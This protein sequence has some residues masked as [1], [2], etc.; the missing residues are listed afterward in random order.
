MKTALHA[1]HVALEAKMADVAGWEMPL[2]YRSVLDEYG[3]ARARAS[4]FDISHIGRLRIRGDGAL[5]LLE[6]LCTADVAHQED[7]TA[8]YTLLCNERGGI[9]DDCLLLR[10]EGCWLLTTNAINRRKVLEH[11]QANAGDDVKVDDQTEKTSQLAVIGPAAAEILDAV[12]PMKVSSMPAGAVKTGSLLIARYVAIRTGCGGNWSL[13]VILPNMA[14]SMAWDFITKKAGANA[15]TPAG[16]AARDLLRFEAGLPRYG[17]E[18]NET[19]D[20]VAAGV[21]FA[22]DFEKNFIGAD[23][24]R[25]VRDKGP[26]RRRVGLVL[27]E[28]KGSAAKPAIPRQGATVFDADGGEIGT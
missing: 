9:V 17:W 14:A 2:S 20:P 26:A 6:R 7:D 13:E 16:L 11:I 28:P 10:L 24:V 23:A 27:A 22:V 15:I 5:D 21:E 19:I 8:I 12:G 25:A 4:V 1:R 18:I 3:Q